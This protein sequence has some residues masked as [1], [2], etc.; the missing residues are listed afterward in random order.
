MTTASLLRQLTIETSQE[1]FKP[2]FD[3]I[4]KS[5]G[6]EPGSSSLPF[7]QRFLGLCDG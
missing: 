5:W 1:G 3:E 4:K 2:V 6:L 7:N